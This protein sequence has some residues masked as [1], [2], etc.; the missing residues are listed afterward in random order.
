MTRIN[1]S[2]PHQIP[3]LIA[4]CTGEPKPRVANA[5][6]LE[7]VCDE[8]REA[9][10]SQIAEGLGLARA[11]RPHEAW[12]GSYVSR[13]GELVLRLSGRVT[14]PVPLSA[15]VERRLRLAHLPCSGAWVVTALR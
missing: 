12:D 13:S 15:T 8:M 11:R 4:T 2:W 10:R 1:A 6:K 7:A 5:A 9:C 14:K 3:R